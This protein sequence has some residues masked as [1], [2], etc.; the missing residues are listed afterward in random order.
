MY[1]SQLLYALYNTVLLTRCSLHDQIQ[2]IRRH[3][4]LPPAQSRRRGSSSRT[5]LTQIPGRTQ[6]SMWRQA[7]RRLAR[8]VSMRMRRARSSCSSSRHS[9]ARVKGSV[10]DVSRCRT[11]VDLPQQPL[12]SEKLLLIDGKP[13]DTYRAISPEESLSFFQS[14]PL[15]LTVSNKIA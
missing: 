3:C 14:S 9:G 10:A 7:L 12:L 4:Q 1:I 11:A 2:G 5:P 15:L 6:Q 8:Q 13:W